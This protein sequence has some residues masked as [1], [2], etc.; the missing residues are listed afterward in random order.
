MYL[1]A[2]LIICP[3]IPVSEAMTIVGDEL[4]M[5]RGEVLDRF[6]SLRPAMTYLWSRDD[7]T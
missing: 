7:I 5:Q 4:L 1:V 6:G 2:Y 3:C